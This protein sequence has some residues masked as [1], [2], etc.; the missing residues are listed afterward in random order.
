M[1][2]RTVVLCSA[3]LAVSLLAQDAEATGA[4]VMPGAPMAQTVVYVPACNRKR[5]EGLRGRML[6]ERQ[7][8]DAACVTMARTLVV[9]LSLMEGRVRVQP[10]SWEE[11]ESFEP[12]YLPGQHY[13]IQVGYPRVIWPQSTTYHRG[14]GYA[15]ITA[16]SNVHAIGADVDGGDLHLAGFSQEGGSVPFDAGRS[17]AMQL[18]HGLL[19]P[20][21]SVREQPTA[22]QVLANNARRLVSR[23]AETLPVPGA[24]GVCEGF[25]VTRPRER[26]AALW[27]RI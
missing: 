26:R 19:E 13:R 4:V 22:G 7:A 24:A 21:C 20:H 23:N 6:E 12:R 2:R 11:R 5:A 14:E 25:Q 15:Q 9:G 16:F 8:E 17:I 1:V 18:L 3:M 27:R 10:Y